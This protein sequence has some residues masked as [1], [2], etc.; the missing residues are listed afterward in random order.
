MSSKERLRLD[1]LGR[2]GR[3]EVT[4]MKAAELMGVSYRHAKRLKRRYQEP[5]D[6]GRV[7]AVRGRPACSRQAVEPRRGQREVGNGAEDVRRK[8][9]SLR[10]HPGG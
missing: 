9:Q 1:A 6:A 10:T 4:L 5:G 3:G 8:V 2:V 7:H